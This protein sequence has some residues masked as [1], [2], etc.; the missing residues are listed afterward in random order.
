[1][2]LGFWFKLMAHLFVGYPFVEPVGDFDYSPAQW[3]MALSAAAAAAVGTALFR[4]GHVLAVRRR[5]LGEMPLSI[6]P[7]WYRRHPI[8][9][10]AIA[11][12]GTLALYLV[13]YRFALFQ[14]G[15]IPKVTLPPG[16][17]AILAWTVFAGAPL[18]WAM[19][20]EWELA[21]RPDRFAPLVWSICLLAL[22]ASV[23][24]ASRGTTVLLFAAYACALALHQP[25]SLGR[26]WQT[27][28]WWLPLILTVTLALSLGLVSAFRMKTYVVT[29]GETRQARMRATSGAHIARGEMVEQ[30]L[31]LPVGRWVGLEGLLSVSGS[32]E[33]SL[34]LLAASIREDPKRG[35]DSI[36]QGLSGSPYE[37]QDGFIYLTLPGA[38]AILFYSG[39]LLI[40]LAGMSF[41]TA[42]IAAVE[43]LAAKVTRSLFLVAV[44]G[45]LTANAVSQMSFPYLWLV[46]MVE[47][48]VA[49]C[50]FALLR[51]LLRLLRRSSGGF[52]RKRNGHK[53]LIWQG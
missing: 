14:I 3:D 44:L 26:L 8:E 48:I 25:G 20:T 42:A 10:W 18:A 31:R 6:G 51:H 49:L 7:D 2:V 16:M 11:V 35:V 23:S 45:L 28:R 30:I 32:T 5:G 37:A 41:F 13:N 46:F 22:V 24:M 1:M 36:Y 4:V 52:W 12:L 43:I 34:S 29:E 27:W 17:N 47:T 9:T 15:V 38:P 19:L 50:A 21:R 39:S 40:V 53:R 33:R